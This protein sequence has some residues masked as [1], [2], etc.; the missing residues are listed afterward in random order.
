MHFVIGLV[1]AVSK[2]EWLNLLLMNMYTPIPVA[3]RSKHWV[4]GCSLAGIAG[5]NPAGV[6]NVCRECWVL[7]GRGLCDG[8]IPRLE[9]SYRLC[10]SL[11]VMK[12]N[13][14]PL[15]LQ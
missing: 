14:N 8:P 2:P 3:A 5:S 6:M 15:H 11:N 12:C 13:N 9:E 10:V 4:C 1:I 7:S